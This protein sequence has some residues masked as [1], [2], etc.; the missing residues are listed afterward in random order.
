VAILVV[1]ARQSWQSGSPSGEPPGAPASDQDAG[2]RAVPTALW[3]LAGTLVFGV[4][5]NE[6]H[7]SV[8]QLALGADTTRLASGLAISAW[9][10]LFAGG[11]VLFGFRRSLQPVR[12][13]GLLVAGLAVTKVVL[14]DLSRL[15]A[16]FRV[17]SVLTLGVVSLLVAYLYYQRAARN[18]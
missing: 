15:D 16:L 3:G 7:R 10:A 4:V 8:V 6:L 14:F 1:L 17:G 13:A 12:V 11:L 9:W 5:T 2:W 18:V